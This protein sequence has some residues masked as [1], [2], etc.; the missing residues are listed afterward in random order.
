LVEEKTPIDA[1]RAAEVGFDVPTLAGRVERE[2]DDTLLWTLGW[3]EFGGPATGYEPE[4]RIRGH[5]TIH[6]YSYVSLNPEACSG[7][8]CIISQLVDPALPSTLEEE[9][10]CSEDRLE[11][12][13]DAEYSTSD[14]AVAAIATGYVLQGRPGEPFESPAGTVFTNLRDVDGTLRVFPGEGTIVRGQLIANLMFREERTEGELLPW[15]DLATGHGG[16][17]T[18]LPLIGKWPIPEGE[19]EPAVGELDVGQEGGD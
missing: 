12:G 16:G 9:Y 1:T 8:R 4:T 5:V 10:D 6:S 14:G 2:L 13:I 15:I 3:P 7:R 17:A 19:I 11:L 18:Y